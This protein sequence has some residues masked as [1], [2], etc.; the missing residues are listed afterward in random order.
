MKKKNNQNSNPIISN[1]V[2]LMFDLFKHFIKDFEN[3]KKVKKIDKFDD[4]ILTLE[5]LIIKLQDR[6]QENRMLLEDL[7][8]RVFWG[9]IVIVVLLLL[10]LFLIIR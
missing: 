10:N 1:F 6:L 2:S 9:N 4:K 7:K 3:I 5:H 8:N